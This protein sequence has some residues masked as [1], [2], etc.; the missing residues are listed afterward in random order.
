[1]PACDGNRTPKVQE[2]SGSDNDCP[3]FR[4]QLY[5]GYRDK[6]IRASL[7]NRKCIFVELAIQ[8][9]QVKYFYIYIT[10][11]SKTKRL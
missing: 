10:I 8:I 9:G 4:K 3:S 5:L 7:T 11:I 6:I 2:S 1:M